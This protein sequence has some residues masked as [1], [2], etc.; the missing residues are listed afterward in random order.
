MS[1]NAYRQLA[2]QLDVV[3][4]GFPA[5]ESGVELRLLAKIF[6][7]GEAALA[8]VM[9]LRAEPAA[10]IAA[11]AG[12]DPQAAHR[13]LKEMADKGAIHAKKDRPS[14]ALMPFMFGF[15]EAQLPRLDEEMAVLFE[16]YYQETQGILVRGTPSVQRVIPIEEAIPVGVEVFPYEQAT[17]LLEGANSWAVRDCICRVQKRLVGEGCEHPLE[18]C[19]TFAP[20][21]GAF[22]HGHV[23]RD[24]TKAEALQ[25]LREAKEAGLVHTTGNYRLG[26]SYI[27][28]CCTCSCALLRG[29]AEFG[30]LN[31]VAHSDF[32]AAVD[33]GLC[34]GCN[35]CV[36]QCQFS[37][38]SVPG[39]VCVVKAVRC[40]GCGQCVT[41]CPTGAMR[42]KHRP[43][44]ER[45]PLPLDSK[46]WRAQRAE[47]RG[48]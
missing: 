17:A 24:L 48:A 25:I 10:D 31:A 21:E 33:Y 19:L 14:F 9:S 42:L 35:D 7:P 28:N 1:E 34:I 3:S 5:T 26:H 40:V 41:V 8:A 2:R 38:L 32:V 27:C 23:G 15:Y 37:A 44:G 39:D 43:E 45:L 16:Q 13:M 46:E 47:G 36:E 22:D 12:V 6:T 4:N 18:N 11:R 30:L 29:M 20:K